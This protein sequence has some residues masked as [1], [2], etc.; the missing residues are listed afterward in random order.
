MLKFQ[1]NKRMGLFLIMLLFTAVTLLVVSGCG[2]QEQ[3]AS[4]PSTPTD[5]GEVKE[6]EPIVIGLVQPLTGP[7]ASAG[8]GVK[9][10]ATIAVEKI[11]NEGG[12][13]G[14]PIK[15]IVEDGEND[16]AKSANAAQKLITRDNVV[17]LM[18]AWGSSPT[19]S[20]IPI[21]REAGVPLLVETGSSYK[22]TDRNEQGNEWTFR[23]S[24]PSRQEAA[25]VK[26]I[27][28]DELGFDKVFFLSVNNDWGRGAALEF[29]KVIESQGG[30]V[31]GEEYYEQNETNFIPLL[32]RAKNSDANSIIITTDA[33]Q[34][35][36]ILDQ[37]QTVGIEQKIMTTGGSNFPDKVI[38]LSNRE[39][40]EGVYSIIF[41]SAAYDESKSQ[42]PE[43]S[44]YFNNEWKRRNLPWEEVVEGARGYDGIMTLVAALKM[45]PED[46]ITRENVRDA[47]AQVEVKG[48]IYGNIS[49]GEWDTFINQNACE[50]AVV[51]VKDGEVVFIKDPVVAV[52]F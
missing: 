14:R 1:V 28:V 52:P 48:I 26:D 6:K 13:N 50:A 27:L 19:L 25:V 24:P 17:A 46:G 43:E 2:G 45:L 29:A 44:R 3:G 20:M 34:I 36:L 49:F 32:Q 9:D 4:Q 23:V 7:I 12:I 15:L 38:S 51:Q 39:A 47:L 33:P 22:I 8:I 30:T 5:N 35:A 40:N 11:N 21:A 31:V 10:G 16:P 42:N 18:G 41:Y 37:A